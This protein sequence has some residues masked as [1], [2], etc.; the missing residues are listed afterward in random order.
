MCGR[1]QKNVR[2]SLKKTV[3]SAVREEASCCRRARVRHRRLGARCDVVEVELAAMRD[4]R[5]PRP[6]H[7]VAADCTGFHQ[8]RGPAPIEDAALATRQVEED[9]LQLGGRSEAGSTPKEQPI[10]GEGRLDP[11]CPGVDADGEVAVRAG[12]QVEEPELAEARELGRFGVDESRA[13]DV[14]LFGIDLRRVDQL[15]APPPS[16]CTTTSKLSDSRLSGIRSN[17]SLLLV[18]RLDTQDAAA[19]SPFH[20]DPSSARVSGRVPRWQVPSTARCSA[21][22]AKTSDLPPLSMRLTPV[23]ASASKRG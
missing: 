12:D 10:A 1:P 11:A 21:S 4:V 17:P 14:G 7:K 5:A 20:I 22:P 19:R 23:V 15:P 8:Q 9:D 2:L 6:G 18:P 13:V 16:A 3:P